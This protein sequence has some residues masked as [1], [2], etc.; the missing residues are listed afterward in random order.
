V[1]KH[2]AQ[3]TP[4]VLDAVVPVL[5]RRRLP[6]HDPFAGPGVHLA[7]RCDRLGRVFSGT[8]IE[9]VFLADARVG[10]GD[11]TEAATYPTVGEQT[12]VSGNFVDATSAAYDPTTVEVIVRAPDGTGS[13]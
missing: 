13:D 7:A 5:E 10:H 4:A 6:V 9:D 2:P 11:S 8:E 3:F 12:I 1:P